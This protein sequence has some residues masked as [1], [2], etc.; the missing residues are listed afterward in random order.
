MLSFPRIRKMKELIKSKYKSYFFAGLLLILL[1]A[2]FSTGFYHIDEHFQIL[3]FASW[4][5][6]NT[7]SLDLPWEFHQQV[8]SALLP[9]ITYLISKTLDILGLYNPF[10]VTFLLRLFTGFASWLITCHLCLHLSQNMKTEKGKKLFILM[11][12]FLWFIPFLSVRFTIENIAGITFLYGVYILLR[13]LEKDN[14]TIWAY[15]AAGLLFGTSFFIRAPLIIAILAFGFW[16]LRTK[17]VGLRNISIL[18][19]SVL[20]AIGLN[21]CLDSWFYEESVFTLSNFIKLYIANCTHGIPGVGGN[22]WWFY[23]EQF[24]LRIT[25][26]ISLF[27]LAIFSIGVY[28][29][30]KDPFVWIIIPF[31]ITHCIIRHKELRFLFPVVFIFIYVSALGLDYLLTK[32]AY[33]KWHKYIYAISVVIVLPLLLFRTFYPANTPVNYYRYIYNHIK[34]KNTPLF[35]LQNTEAQSPWNTFNP[36]LFLQ[37]NT[38]DYNYLMLNKDFYKNPDVNSAPLKNISEL[39]TSLD[40]IKPDIAYYIHTSGGEFTAPLNGYKITK[41]YSLSPTWLASFMEK[42]CYDKAAGWK[43]YQLSKH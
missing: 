11:S 1:C 15:I 16:L 36:S 19:T 5:M 30:R 2:W 32:K 21:T 18:F 17:K 39:N 31:V 29:N 22:P 6:G 4:K 42:Y 41:V 26:P 12:L 10:T 38:N 43:I 25:P 7:S 8:R 14:N 28:K 35:I 27:L 3:E 40:S 34:G 23:I 24:A 13:T 9:S 33:L 20:V 37:Q